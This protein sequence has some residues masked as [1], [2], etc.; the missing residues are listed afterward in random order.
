M[1]ARVVCAELTVNRDGQELR[2][3]FGS[4]IPTLNEKKLKGR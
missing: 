4:N 1:H 3:E 2:V